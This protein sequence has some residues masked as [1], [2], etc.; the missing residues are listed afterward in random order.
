MKYVLL[1]ITL[2]LPTLC[3]AEGGLKPPSDL[4]IGSMVASLV[5]VLACIFVFAFLMKKSNLIR[6]AN[7]NSLIKVIATQPLTNK[8][9]VQIIEVDQKRYLIGVTEQNINLLD[10]LPLP[11]EDPCEPT[12]GKSKHSFSTLLSKISTKRNE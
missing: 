11:E 9:R 2:F 5:L 6:N 12:D 10:T 3:W 4:S 8:G 7:G 1:F